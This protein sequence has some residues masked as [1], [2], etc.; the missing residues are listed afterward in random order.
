MD[1][2]APLRWYRR[3]LPEKTLLQRGD[4]ERLDPYFASIC[5]MGSDDHGPPTLVQ[6][7]FRGHLDAG[8]LAWGFARVRCPDRGFERLSFARTPSELKP[9]TIRLRA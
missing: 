6:R 2:C 9:S 4:R 7:E 8:T 5:E 3:R 1:S